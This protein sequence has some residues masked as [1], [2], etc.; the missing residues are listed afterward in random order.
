MKLLALITGG[1][2]GSDLF[3]SLLD[4]HSQIMQF[5]GTFLFDDFYEQ[6]KNEKNS[7]IIAQSFIR[8]EPFFFNSSKHY[9]EKHNMLGENKNEY[10]KVDKDLFIKNFTKIF[11][12]LKGNKMHLLYS[13]HAAYTVASGK[14]ITNK[15][16]IVLDIH[17]IKRLRVLNSLDY[18][19]IYMLRDPLA[20]LSSAVKNWTSYE[21]GVHF[22]PGA[23][24][25]HIDRVI[26][27]I[28]DTLKFNKKTFVI[29]LEK[30][31]LNFDSVIKEFCNIYNL[32]F[33]NSLN[34]STFH[35]KKWWGDAIGKKFLN[36]INKNF[37][38]NFDHNDYFKKDVCLLE[39]CLKDQISYYNYSFRSKFKT[40][41]N[42]FFTP[43]KF[44]LLIWKKSMIKFRLK[45]ILS[46]PIFWLYRI[47]SMKKNSNSKLP[48]SLGES[49]LN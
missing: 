11:D 2:N 49:N 33:E 39:E 8:F 27:G 29:Q 30:L 26:N 41:Y 14:D 9:V 40:K 32:K 17:H 19:I 13:L 21:D 6:I 38:N 31:H 3:L 44:E 43:L 36:G 20:N 28:S 45:H 12:N 18:D 46:I 42:I 1:R 48:R 22:G 5:P 34:Y 35:G 16:V 4:G 23:L 7:N 47:N 10:F 24:F 15:K 25:Q 37:K